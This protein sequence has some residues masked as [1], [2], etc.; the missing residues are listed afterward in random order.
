MRKKKVSTSYTF[1]EFNFFATGSTFDQ[2]YFFFAMKLNNSYGDF[3]EMDEKVTLLCSNR[4]ILKFRKYFS[5]FCVKVSFVAKMV[6]FVES[7]FRR[8]KWWV[9]SKVSFVAK[10][11][12]FVESEFRR[13]NFCDETH[14][15]PGWLQQRVHFD[16]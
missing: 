8:K 16:V 5:L 9:S 3:L 6:S 14:P 13:K 10:T 11:V 2:V 4:F 12:S 1:C 15:S 7:E